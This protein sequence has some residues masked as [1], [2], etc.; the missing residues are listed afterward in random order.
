M[1]SPN[2]TALGLCRPLRTQLELSTR[3][4]L[5]GF[6]VGPARARPWASWDWPARPSAS[7]PL[8]LARATRRNKDLVMCGGVGPI[9]TAPLRHPGARADRRKRVS[10]TQVRQC[11]GEGRG[12]GWMGGGRRG[13]GRMDGRGGGREV[14][15]QRFCSGRGGVHIERLKHP[16]CSLDLL[17]SE[18]N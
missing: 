14:L 5:G 2:P 12:G 15:E 9:P 16:W 7:Y 6:M 1:G 3:G 8:F 10:A 11:A 4:L 13:G 17:G 18:A